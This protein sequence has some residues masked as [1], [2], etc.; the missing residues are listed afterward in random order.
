MLCL[1]LAAVLAPAL[2]ETRASAAP[3]SV[4]PAALPLIATVDPRFQSYNIEM[5]EVV[6]GEFWKPAAKP[7]DNAAQGPTT[8]IPSARDPAG[9]FGTRPPIDLRDPRLRNLAA[10]LGAAY[11][12]VSGDWAN[13]IYFWDSDDPAPVT[14]PPG[15]EGVLTRRAWKG[16]VDFAQAVDARLVTSFAVGAGVRDA[17]GTWTPAQARALIAYTQSLGGA[18][19]AAEFFNEPSFA[20]TID[21]RPYGAAAYARDTAVFRQFI[22]TVAPG[23][24]IVGPG[25]AGEGLS[26]LPL[27][28]LSTAELLAAEPRPQVDVFSYHSYAAASQRCA[29][30]GAGV[31]RTTPA[32]ALSED[33]LARPDRIRA[34][35]QGLRDRFA[36]SRPI[37]VTETAE[38]A[39]GGD[40]WA[41]RF[42]DSFRYLDQLGR[43]AK[44]GIAAV[45]HN[46][47]AAS[48]YG[49][50][51]E[52]DLTPRPDY[53]AALLWRRLMGPAVLD[54]GPARPG[55]H[56]YAQCLPDMP[57]G[58]TLLVINT[59]RT[60]AAEVALPLPAERYTL[61]ARTLDDGWVRLNG[62]VLRARK[63]GTIPQ[64]AGERI[65]PGRVDIA[66][67]SIAFLAVAEAGNG[68]CR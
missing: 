66:P 39:C 12:R 36:P 61:T 20:A 50:L 44:A 11:L 59:S 56:L 17:G 3:L 40:P 49:L 38:A 65:P 29:A 34:F 68:A 1:V 54:A 15:F 30:L 58:V 23:T 48:D 37:W 63:D 27:P 5:A 32:A 46:T 62:S 6:G 35:Y 22:A 42:R 55:L 26:L 25:S 10:A 24:P 8:T 67:E 2:L 18:I 43:L 19:A 53:W 13:G 47:L 28:M 51:D 7:S 45:F 4:D 9:M 60:K 21:G 64:I 16:V 33:W 31:A 14:P 57:G 41:S 52:R